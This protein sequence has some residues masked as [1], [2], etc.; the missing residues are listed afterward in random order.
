[1]AKP[2]PLR[3]EVDLPA[4]LGEQALPLVVGAQFVRPLRGEEAGCAALAGLVLRD[5]V[6]RGEAE[7]GG[8]GP[9]A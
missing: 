1:M 7:P 2:V 4:Q 3:E 9:S 8:A 6:D 5:R